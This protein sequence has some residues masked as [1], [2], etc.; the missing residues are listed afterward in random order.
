PPRRP[1]RPHVLAL[2]R[3]AEQRQPEACARILGGLRDIAHVEWVGGAAR[4][5]CSGRAALE[6]AAVPVTGWLPRPNAQSRL[7][8]ATAYLHWTAWDGQPL[9]GPAALA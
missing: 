9:P 4:A 1:G 8:A 5:G 2:G 7:S 6:T 3:I